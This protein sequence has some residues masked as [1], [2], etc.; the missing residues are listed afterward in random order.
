MQGMEAANS[1]SFGK[2]LRSVFPNIKT[3]RLGTR[4]QSK[5]HYYGL[6]IKDDSPYKNIVLNTQRVNNFNVN[7]NNCSYSRT[8]SQTAIPGYASETKPLVST[9]TEYLQLTNFPLME[10]VRITPSLEEVEDK[11]SVLLILYRHHCQR[12]AGAVVHTNFADVEHHVSSFWNS[13]PGHIQSIF[14]L[15]EVIKLL[16]L[17]DKA[18]YSTINRILFPTMTQQLAM[19]LKKAIRSFATNLVEWVGSALTMQSE[20]LKLALITSKL[21]ALQVPV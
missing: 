9:S 8:V 2:I 17:S 10:N 13:I 15:P 16:V 3:R 19:S 7:S 18:T 20:V 12:I 21:K 6:S 11:V 14:N 5:Y 4:G 1:A